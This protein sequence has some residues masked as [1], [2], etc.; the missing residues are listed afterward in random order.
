MPYSSK[1]E[2]L[3]YE[4]MHSIGLY[5]QRQYLISKHRV[6]FA[7][8]QYKLAIE[9]DGPHHRNFSQIEIDKKRR[10]VAEN[11]GWTVR[12]FSA[13]RAYNNPQDIAWEIKHLL[14]GENLESQVNDYLSHDDYSVGE[15]GTEPYM[16]IGFTLLM[17]AIAW[18]L[19][20][21]LKINLRSK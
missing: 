15:D 10:D 12:R 13:E 19:H 20:Y 18:T 11:L 14:E 9:I 2:D 5:P 1:T 6:D 7:F 21:K 8:P 4:A 17:A 16:I 3:L